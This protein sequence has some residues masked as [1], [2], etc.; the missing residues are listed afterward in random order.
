M[1]EQLALAGRGFAAP[2]REWA[3]YR[4]ES[5]LRAWSARTWKTQLRKYAEDAPKFAAAVEH[6]IANGWQGL[7]PPKETQGGP[8]GRMTEKQAGLA[9]M[10]E[11]AD[12][13]S[14]IERANGGFR[15]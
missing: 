7:F 14:Q 1:I 6:S 2:C 4:R 8:N 5:K 13:L 10:R 11:A 3:E 9:R 12:R 15:R